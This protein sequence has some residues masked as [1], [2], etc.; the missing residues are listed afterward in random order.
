MHVTYLAGIVG[1]HPRAAKTAGHSAFIE[2]GA[3]KHIL[4]YRVSLLCICAVG[5]CTQKC[6]DTYSYI[7]FPKVDKTLVYTEIDLYMHVATIA[8]YT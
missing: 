3:S 1:S 8:K 6:L 5:I 2:S 7:H 4:G